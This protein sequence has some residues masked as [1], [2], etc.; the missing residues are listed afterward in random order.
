VKSRHVPL[1]TCL[2]CGV[3]QPQRQLVRIV[4]ASSEW[5]EIDFKRVKHGRGG[6]L[7]HSRECWQRIWEKGLLER[8]FRTAIPSQA[9]EYLWAQYMQWQ[10]IAAGNEAP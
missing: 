10:G 7:C 2:A 3:K 4:R 8:A 5:V 6:Y 1:R 9:R